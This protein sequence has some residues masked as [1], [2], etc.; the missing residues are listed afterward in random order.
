MK[1]FSSFISEAKRS[2]IRP[3]SKTGDEN[4]VG[5]KNNTIGTVSITDE[6]IDEVVVSKPMSAKDKKALQAYAIKH[7]A[8]LAAHDTGI[9]PE[10]KTFKQFN[11]DQGT[12]KH[13]PSKMGLRHAIG[14]GYYKHDE[15]TVNELSPELVGKVNK[16][17]LD[18]PSKT[19][20]AQKTLDLAV[21]KAWLKSKVGIKKESIE[22][23]RGR[24]K[25][26]PTA[27]DPGSDNIIMQLR[28][29]ITLRGQEPVKFVNGQHVKIS[30]SY[31]HSILAKYDN[32]K[33]SG[34][35]HA[36]SARLHKSPESMRDAA[37]G[38]AEPKKA[39]VSL[40]GKIT[41]TQNE[42]TV[43]T[44]GKARATPVTMSSSPSV[45]EPNAPSSASSLQKAADQR[46]QK[47]DSFAQKQ[48]E[49]QAKQ[50]EVE[51]KKREAIAKSNDK[52]QKAK[53]KSN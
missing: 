31:A 2:K 41:G 9:G 12:H 29:V 21:K 15:E 7:R 24:P 13:E 25:K 35:K 53:Q 19:T 39:A 17:R 3:D 32:L 38:R 33:T 44:M 42:A 52:I 47:L 40:A 11:T 22:E 36:F 14:A 51:V 18:K 50:R 45:K 6:K 8:K 43:S 34:E 10:K 5:V 26:N 28:K 16:A 27:E 1:S 20:A 4:G 30:P 46:R 37:S 49:L 48:T 23:A